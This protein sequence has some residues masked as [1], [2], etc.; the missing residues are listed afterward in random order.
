[1]H[2]KLQLLFHRNYLR[3]AIPTANLVSFDWGE[4]LAEYGPGYLDNNVFLID[5]PFVGDGHAGRLMKRKSER[6][7]M[8]ASSINQD[9]IVK[10]TQTIPFLRNLIRFLLRADYPDH[11][12]TSLLAFDFSKTSRVDFIA[13]IGGYHGGKA[14]HDSGRLA[15]ARAARQAGL[16]AINSPRWT[17]L[18]SSLG[19]LDWRFLNSLARAM[20]SESVL[21]KELISEC[22][23]DQ[24]SSSFRIAFPTMK[25]VKNAAAGAGVIFFSRKCIQDKSKKKDRSDRFPEPCLYEYHPRKA[26]ILSHSKAII[27][28]DLSSS[29]H[30]L[31]YIGSAN[32]SASAWYACLSNAQ[33]NAQGR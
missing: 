23:I 25:A 18:T 8:M 14:I 10:L 19:S 29:G 1:M 15:L 16:P 26:G 2:S 28:E 27:C 22:A 17:A 20:L 5:L 9:Q 30:G 33:T 32:L 7:A 21:G 13:T 6:N 24:L 4:E 3:I 12:I 11:V 31:A